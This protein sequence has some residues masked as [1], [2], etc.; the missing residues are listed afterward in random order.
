[1]SEGWGMTHDSNY[2][3]TS[4]GTSTIF[5]INP[6]DFSVISSFVVFDEDG[7]TPIEYMNELELVGDY[8]YANVLPLNIVIKFSK[9][10]G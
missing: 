3:Y 5:K 10:S 6:T 2:I 9:H 8:I 7:S 1:M 4:D